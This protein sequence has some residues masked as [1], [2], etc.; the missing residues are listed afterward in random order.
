M[1][2]RGRLVHDSYLYAAQDDAE[3][4]QVKSG[5]PSVFVSEATDSR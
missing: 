4:F 2:K 3:H 5:G 1:S